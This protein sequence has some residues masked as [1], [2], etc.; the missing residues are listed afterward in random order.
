VA[1]ADGLGV[2][3]ATKEELWSASPEKVLGV[4][5]SWAQT[6]KQA[7]LAL[8]RALVR[9]CRWLEEPHN[10]A[11]AAL[12]LA[13]PSYVGVAAEIIAEPLT[14]Q[15]VLGAGRKCM[16][17]DMVVFHRGHANYPW[18][19]HA[20]WFLSQMIRWGQVRTPFDLDAI[21]KRVYRPDHYR[22]AAQTLG[23]AVPDGDMRHEP[24]VTFF[25]GEKFE[26]ERPLTYLAGLGIRS[27][28]TDLAAFAEV[29]RG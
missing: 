26:P 11:E 5:E 29:N 12:L 19:S 25:G 14:G 20:L 22:L 8:V 21:A 10:H 9:S 28:A 15:M 24:P 27:P 18:R 3:V 16:V 2:I 6:H 23:I 17:Q 4:R 7:L 13:R 1:V